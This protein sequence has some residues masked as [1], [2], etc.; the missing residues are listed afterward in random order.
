M[1]D[2]FGCPVASRK[3]IS[4]ENARSVY[5]SNEF[6]GNRFYVSTQMY[7]SVLKESWC[8]LVWWLSSANKNLFPVSLAEG[9]LAESPACQ[10]SAGFEPRNAKTE[11]WKW[12]VSSFWI[13]SAECCC[14]PRIINCVSRCRPCGWNICLIN[15]SENNIMDKLHKLLDPVW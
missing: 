14:E 12:T 9:A 13:Q 11:Q 1:R 8:N 6:Y 3:A 15:G 2:Y 5:F 4:L 7:L 10:D